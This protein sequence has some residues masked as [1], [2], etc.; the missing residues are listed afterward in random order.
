MKSPYLAISAALIY[1]MTVAAALGGTG[2]AIAIDPNILFRESA[3]HHDA[4]RAVHDA[5]FG[6]WVVAEFEEPRPDGS[7]WA[8]QTINGRFEVIGKIRD[9]WTGVELFNADQALNLVNTIPVHAMTVFNSDLVSTLTLG[10]GSN[11]AW[12]VADASNPKTPIILNELIAQDYQITVITGNQGMNPGI[13]RRFTCA[14][15]SV[16]E[17]VLLHGKVHLLQGTT[18]QCTDDKQQLTELLLS[19]LAIQRK[20][21]IVLSSGRLLQG[22]AAVETH[23]G[24]R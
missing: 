1:G 23:L 12:M 15:D 19:V 10:D 4:I 5:P 21:S 18:T 2:R 7:L 22:S 24:L 6:D 14:A 11:N 9:N 16:K 3:I 17:D 13:K 20:P 8:I